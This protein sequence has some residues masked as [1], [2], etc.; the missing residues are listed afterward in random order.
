MAVSTSDKLYLVIMLY[1]YFAAAIGTSRILGA[2]YNTWQRFT[3]RPR[4]GA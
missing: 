4:K 3:S 1:I 2:I